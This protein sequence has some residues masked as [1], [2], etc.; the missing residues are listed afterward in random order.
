[1]SL[2]QGLVLKTNRYNDCDLLVRTL[3]EFGLVNFYAYQQFPNTGEGPS[4]PIDDFG[5]YQFELANGKNGALIFRRGELIESFMEH[6]NLTQYYGACI[7]EELIS[8]TFEA[9][10]LNDYQI[11]YHSFLDY[12]RASAHD[13][14]LSVTSLVTALVRIIRVLGYGFKA[15]ACYACGRHDEI[16]G[17]DLTHFGFVCRLCYDPKTAIITKP[18]Y[19]YALRDLF[20]TCGAQQIA[21]SCPPA[22]ADQLLDD[23][24]HLAE[25]SLEIRLASYQTYLQR[26]PRKDGKK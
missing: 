25:N 6:P 23:V 11:V 24:I 15:D 17:Y 3:T 21:P 14:G 19:L 2:I 1:M 4:L 5:L 18:A 22:L 16:I 8:K 20:K 10:E 13:S 12:L 9:T 7:L 26:R